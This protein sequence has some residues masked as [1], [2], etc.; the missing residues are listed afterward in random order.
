MDKHDVKVE[1][2][3]HT[4]DQDILNGKQYGNFSEYDYVPTGLS[5]TRNKTLA[6]AIP[7]P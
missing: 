7:H 4:F 5:I 1:N 2:Q 6:L 3:A